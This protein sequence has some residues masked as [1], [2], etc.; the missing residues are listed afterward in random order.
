MYRVSTTIWTRKHKFEH[1]S[2][3]SNLILHFY[4]L[5]NWLPYPCSTSLPLLISNKSLSLKKMKYDVNMYYA[6]CSSCSFVMKYEH[7]Q[8]A[9]V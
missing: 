6:Y 1:Q 5:K 2:P 9:N 7:L 8:V 4:C 3:L